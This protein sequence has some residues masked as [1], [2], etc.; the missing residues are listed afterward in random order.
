MYR[1]FGQALLGHAGL[2][3]GSSQFQVMTKPPRKIV[4]HVKSKSLIHSVTTRMGVKFCSCAEGLKCVRNKNQLGTS[5]S[6]Q[7]IPS[8]GSESLFFHKEWKE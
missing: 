5:E 8:Y 3:L 2:A 7:L 1:G 4:V 6:R